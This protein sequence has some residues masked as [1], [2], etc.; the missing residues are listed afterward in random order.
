MSALRRYDLLRSRLDSFTRAL[1]GVTS[2]EP[3]AIHR[4]RVAL[5]RLRELLPVLELDSATIRKVNRRL[6]KLTRRLGGVREIDVLTQ[7]LEELL[8][9]RL[10]PVRALRRVSDEVRETRDEV[11]SG[12]AHKSIDESFHRADRKLEHIAE[13]LEKL[14][15]RG[16]RGRTWRWA[17]DA[18]VSR[19][20]AAL[21]TAM[22]DAG[23]MYMPERLH[24]VRVALK[25]LRYGV[26][27]SCE[28]GGFAEAADVRLLKRGQDLLGLLRDRQVLIARVRQVQASLDPPD[29]TAWRELD[30]LILSLEHSCRGIHARYLQSQ[31]RLLA[32]CDRFGARASAS[33]ARRA[34]V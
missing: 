25:K 22:T 11:M 19:R 23:S 33:A 32:L 16:S 28:A 27:L 34:A 9:A 5:R 10:A 4:A 14:D 24:Q 26:E 6:K 15:D 18:R 2:G 8:G 7:L 17:I 31:S 30:A 20:A 13:K 1:P 12:F 21:K 3:R 29:M